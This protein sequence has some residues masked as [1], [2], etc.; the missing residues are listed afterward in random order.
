MNQSPAAA[1]QTPKPYGHALA[2]V[3]E[4]IVDLGPTET[5][6]LLDLFAAHVSQ[7]ITRLHRGGDGN[8]LAALGRI[9]HTMKGTAG[10][11]RRYRTT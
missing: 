2:T 10:C 11:S 5:G 1:I 9:A 6:E 4:L 3:E 7:T 8:S